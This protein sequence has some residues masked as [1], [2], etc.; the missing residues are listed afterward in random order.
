M[1]IR[2]ESTHS[3][4][5]KE[6]NLF[7]G[8]DN[9]VIN[10]IFRLGLVQ[11]FKKGDHIIREGMH[12]GNLHILINGKAEVVKGGLKGKGKGQSLAKLQRGSVFGEMSVFDG[13]PYSASVRALEDCDIHIIRGSDFENFLQGNPPAAYGIFRTL[14]SSISNRLRRTNLALS[15]MEGRK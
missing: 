8:L 9:K 6:V 13:A 5:L 15:V 10:Q 2:K 7:E 3:N 11:N 12:G 14:L 1:V 4:F